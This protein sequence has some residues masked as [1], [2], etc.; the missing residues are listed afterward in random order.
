MIFHDFFGLKFLFSVYELVI[1]HF[2]ILNGQLLAPF[3]PLVVLQYDNPY[4]N[5]QIPQ[6]WLPIIF[7]FWRQVLINVEHREIINFVMFQ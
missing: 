1:N 6:W 7:S 4:S 2:D 3:N 5:G